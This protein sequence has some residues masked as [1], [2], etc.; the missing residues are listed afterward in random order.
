MY[1]YIVYCLTIMTNLEMET[2]CEFKQQNLE[3][4]GKNNMLNL[5]IYTAL[6]DS[7]ASPSP[8]PGF[9]YTPNTHTT[10]QW[11]QR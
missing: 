8:H 2:I 7:N 4:T 10:S 3:N 1:I 6:D 11:L 9:I 5:L